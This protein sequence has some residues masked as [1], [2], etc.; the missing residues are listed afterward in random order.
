MG[1]VITWAH[2]VAWKGPRMRGDD[3]KIQKYRE[4]SVLLITFR[5]KSPDT[6]IEM[7]LRAMETE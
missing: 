5:H 4:S 7:R 3:K 1:F 6:I 2:I